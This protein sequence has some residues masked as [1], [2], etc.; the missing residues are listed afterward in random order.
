MKHQ[1]KTNNITPDRDIIASL[2]TSEIVSAFKKTEGYK[3]FFQQCHLP[4][5][6]KKV[7]WFSIFNVSTENI[8]FFYVRYES[9]IIVTFDKQE[10]FVNY[11][12]EQI[13]HLLP[14]KQFFRLN[15]Q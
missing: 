13:Q 1:S 15:R 5:L 6:V 2:G 3:N 14:E 11:S 4:N 9:S 10:F 12:L 7:S 8:A